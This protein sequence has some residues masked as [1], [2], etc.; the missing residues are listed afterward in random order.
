MNSISD[1]THR[2]LQGETWY[3]ELGPNEKFNCALTYCL[4]KYNLNGSSNWMENAISG[5]KT[6]K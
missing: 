4:S 1:R 2:K 5:K 6:Q 3:I